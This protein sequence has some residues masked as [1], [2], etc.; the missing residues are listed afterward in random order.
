MPLTKYQR[1]NQLIEEMSQGRGFA[2]LTSGQKTELNRQLSEEFTT[3]TQTSEPVSIGSTTARDT[4][5]KNQADI[6]KINDQLANKP[7]PPKTEPPKPE[8]AGGLSQAELTAIGAGKEETPEEK[9][10]RESIRRADTREDEIRQSGEED[11]G[12]RFDM[13]LA[14]D[15]DSDR[16][17]FAVRDAKGEWNILS[18]NE[19]W[20]ILA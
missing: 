14:T 20:S 6:Q 9:N 12:F 16:A 5:D 18:A 2:L 10:I 17:A 1:R 11:K 3:N 13:V 8:P 19:V 15:P 7:E 4:T